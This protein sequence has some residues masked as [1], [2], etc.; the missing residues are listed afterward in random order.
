[1]MTRVNVNL[2]KW[3][4]GSDERLLARAG[5]REGHVEDPQDGSPLRASVAAPASVQVIGGDAS[6]AVG[7]TGQRHLRGGLQDEIAHLDGVADRIDIR[8]ARLHLVVHANPAT[9]TDFQPRARR[10]LVLGT[11]ADAEHDD[12]GGQR[13]AGLR[14]GD[15]P[16]VGM[17]GEGRHGI[18]QQQ[19][20]ASFPQMRRGVRRHL[21]IPGRQ[22]LIGQFE[23]GRGHAS[24][25]KV[26]GHFESDETGADDK[27]RL[28]AR[29]ERR[30]DPIAVAQ[31]AQRVNAGQVRARERRPERR[32]RPA[33]GSTGRT[34][35]HR[36]CR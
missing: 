16:A 27:R 10:Q 24:A 36:S 7:W 34:I 23:D 35:P 33:I 28:G 12:V 4:A 18:A 21:A 14:R 8:V 20:D 30:L 31:I 26:L 2:A 11:H 6:L 19:A 9:G 15:Q 13:R 22:D 17:C 5:Q 32:L 25:H 29:V 1:M 3:P